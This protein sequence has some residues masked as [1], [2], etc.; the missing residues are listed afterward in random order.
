MTDWYALSDRQII[1]ALQCGDSI[2]RARQAFSSWRAQIE[3]AGQQRLSLSPVD[4]RRMEL[5]AV[6]AIVAALDGC[7]LTNRISD[8]GNRLGLV[9][10]EVRQS[11]GGWQAI[12]KY[13]G[14]EGG[15]WGVGCDADMVTALDKALITGE[16]MLKIEISNSFD[17]IL[18]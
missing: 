7:S 6:E 17:D 1:D 4:M 5:A 18:G 16:K 3:Q 9:D 12:A 10:L 2:A 15:P 13:R 8:H 11:I 14:H